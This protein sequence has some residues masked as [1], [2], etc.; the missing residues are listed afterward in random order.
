MPAAC[1]LQYNTL[2]SYLHAKGD[3][4]GE[5]RVLCVTAASVR[6]KPYTRGLGFR[7][8]HLRPFTMEHKP[9][10]NVSS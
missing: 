7:G 2:P 8:T 9:F 1:L 6:P 4:L 10:A 5:S 3:G